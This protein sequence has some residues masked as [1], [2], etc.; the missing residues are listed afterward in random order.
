MKAW[1]PE[2][3]EAV[4]FLQI[5]TDPRHTPVLVHCQH[6]ADRTG[7]MCAIYRV[8]VEGWT[9]EEAAQEMTGGG[10]GFHAVWQNLPAW[11]EALDIERL[12]KAAGVPPPKP[13]PPTRPAD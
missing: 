8:A 1:H 13:R 11:I 9:K 4:K 3:K 5:A 10:F 2:Y 7:A 12:R 6:G